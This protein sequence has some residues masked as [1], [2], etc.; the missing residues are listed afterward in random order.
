MK[1]QNEWHPWFAWHPVTIGETAAWLET[2][3]RRWNYTIGEIELSAW[4]YRFPSI[5]QGEYSE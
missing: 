5:W 2:V 3:E 1:D 4:E